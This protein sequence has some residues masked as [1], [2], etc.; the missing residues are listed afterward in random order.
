MAGTTMSPKRSGSSPERRSRS[1]NPKAATISGH[2]A[3]KLRAPEP[4]PA[5]SP[6]PH[7]RR[8]ARISSQS[9]PKLGH[10]TFVDEV[11]ELGDSAVELEPDLAG[12]AVTLLGDDHFR[13]AIDPRHLL[14]PFVDLRMVVGRLTRREIII[15]AVDEEDDV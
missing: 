5:P 4:S 1:S 14:A 8:Q 10:V 6:P 2:E 7:A 11:A 9:A 12:R 15:F 3:H 13:Q